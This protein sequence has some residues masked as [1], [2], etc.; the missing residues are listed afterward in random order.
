M[1][2]EAVSR[3]G[4]Q[5]TTGQQQDGGTSMSTGTESEVDIVIQLGGTEV[6]LSSFLTQTLMF[7]TPRPI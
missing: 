2:R 7:F 5:E 1:Q 6:Q 3:S 4:K